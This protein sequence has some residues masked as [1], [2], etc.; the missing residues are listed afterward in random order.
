MLS[1]KEVEGWLLVRKDGDVLVRVLKTIYRQRKRVSLPSFRRSLEMK[2]EPLA[3]VL[4]QFT[5][6]K[7]FNQFVF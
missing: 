6:T 4:I 1:R 5:G 2:F 3:F 7:L